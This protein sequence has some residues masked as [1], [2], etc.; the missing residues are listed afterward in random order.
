MIPFAVVDLFTLA[1]MAAF[2]R[3]DTINDTGQ[4]PT[5]NTHL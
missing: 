1:G 4:V 5:G 3:S 2:G